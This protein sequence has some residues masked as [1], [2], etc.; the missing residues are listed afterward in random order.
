[1]QPHKRIKMES[2]PHAKFQNPKLEESE[3][4]KLTEEVVFSVHTFYSLG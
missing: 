4:V 1:M 2:W 3:P